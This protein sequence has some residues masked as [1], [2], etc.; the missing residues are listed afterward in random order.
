MDEPAPFNTLFD[1]RNSDRKPTTR[2][3]DTP[4]EMIKL[5]SP[6]KSA[7]SENLIEEVDDTVVPYEEDKARARVLP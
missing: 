2:E 5:T 6:Q 7:G 3:L 1:L 4:V